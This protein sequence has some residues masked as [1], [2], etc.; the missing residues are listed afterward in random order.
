M[1]R[2]S[3]L[4]GALGFSIDGAC[5]FATEERVVE[6]AYDSYGVSCPDIDEERKGTSGDAV[7]CGVAL[8]DAA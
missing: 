2:L 5:M 6:A 3:G 8:K 4:R 1:E 7:S